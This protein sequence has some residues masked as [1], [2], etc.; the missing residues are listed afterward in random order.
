MSRLKPFL[1]AALCALALTAAANNKAVLILLPITV[2]PAD[3]SSNAMVVGVMRATG[4]GFYWLPT[5]GVIQ[6]GG[7]GAAAVS[8]AGE[9]IIGDAENA[10][11]ISQ[12]AIWLRAAEWR[13]LGSIAPNALPCDNLLS[14]SYDASDDGKVIVGLAW[15]G[16][17]IGRAFRWEESTGMVDLGST[18]AGRSSR[19]NGVSGDGR[20]V[21][22]WQDSELGLRRGARWVDGK[23]ELFRGP[24]IITGEAQAANRDGSIIV[25]QSCE[26]ASNANLQANQQAW[27]W[28][29]RD[30]VI[31]LQPPRIRLVNNFIGQALDTSEDG[32]VIGGS[33][34]FGPDA[35]AVIWIDREPA[36][37]KDYLRA[38]GVP[39][40]FEGWVNTG[41]ITGV[42]R[43]GRMLVGYGAGPRDFQ[44]YI[45]MLPELGAQP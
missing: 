20:V 19:A 15:N 2:L 13:L 3:V 45:V 42:S 7:Q 14:S 4:G 29:S 33:Q 40:A 25:G 44:G 26:F 17:N 31:C 16:C 23:Q 35:E 30:G 24:T 32:R 28:T 41:F 12:A 18:V 27:V 22:G 10:Q 36:Y 11:R 6:V 9:S 5:T 38:N 39:D 1:V 8:R 37:L 43:D 34:S 21:V